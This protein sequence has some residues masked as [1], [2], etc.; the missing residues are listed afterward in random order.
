MQRL[1]Q[2]ALA[3]SLT[4]VADHWRNLNGRRVTAHSGWRRRELGTGREQPPP[5]EGVDKFAGGDG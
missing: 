4:L 2:H 3:Q 5:V 1:P